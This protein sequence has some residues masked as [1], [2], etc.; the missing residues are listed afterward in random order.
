MTQRDQRAELPRPGDVA[1][2]GD[3]PERLRIPASRPDAPELDV[4]R[5]PAAR[6]QIVRDRIHQVEP[7]LGP[8]EAAVNQHYHRTSVTALLSELIRVVA[9][10]ERADGGSSSTTSAIRS[11]CIAPRVLCRGSGTVKKC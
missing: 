4:P 8:P 11:Y 10:R 5:R 2:G 1:R 9:E 7:V 3:V 6:R